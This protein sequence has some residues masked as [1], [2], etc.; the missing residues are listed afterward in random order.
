M[1]S[2]TPMM[3]EG[4]WE[5]ARANWP[6]L[7]VPIEALDAYVRARVSADDEFAAALSRLNIPDLYL[8]CACVSGV[9]GAIET[10]ERMLMVR[11]PAFVRQ[12][13]KSSEFADEVCQLLRQK[14]FL[15]SGNGPKIAQYSGQGTLLS[16]L[17]VA[18][19]RT[20]LNLREARHPERDEALDAATLAVAA[21][22]VHLEMV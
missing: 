7:S 18:A 17:R 14:L 19:V 3:L 6:N 22:D 11:V 8:A 4:L 12:V 15:A 1:R 10:F 20:A 9:T 13:D 16:W 2:N 21:Q 5:T